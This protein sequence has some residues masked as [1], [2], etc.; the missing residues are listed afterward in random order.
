MATAIALTGSLAE[1]KRD[2]RDDA[3]NVQ[4]EQQQQ[5]QQQQLQGLPP[6]PQ[7]QE[8]LELRPQ[9]PPTTSQLQGSLP[10]PAVP[11][12]TMQEP[13]PPTKLQD[14]DCHR[15]GTLHRKGALDH[16]R[17]ALVHPGRARPTC[18]A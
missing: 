13:P 10:T 2:R 6:Q 8:A 9:E 12:Q 3:S 5:Q 11:P 14:A 17:G 4:Q 16:Y 15:L 18:G 1:A 7:G